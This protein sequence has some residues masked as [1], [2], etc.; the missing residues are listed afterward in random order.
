MSENE[1]Q[2]QINGESTQVRQGSTVEQLLHDRLKPKNSGDFKAIAVEVNGELLTSAQY[3][4][5]VLH[6]QDQI[7]IVTL[8]GGG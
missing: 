2:I 5:K 1:I 8:V 3:P 4:E 7:E 6:N